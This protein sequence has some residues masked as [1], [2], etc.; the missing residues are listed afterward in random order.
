MPQIRA[1]HNCPAHPSSQVAANQQGIRL[2]Q[3]L[4][5]E[6]DLDTVQAYMGFIQHNAEHAV[7]RMLREFAA[8]H[9]M[10]GEGTVYAEDHM[11]DGSRISLRITIDASSGDAVFDFSGTD[12]EVCGVVWCGVAWCGARAHNP[13][14]LNDTRLQVFGNHNAPPT[15]T[16]SAVIYSLRCLVGTDIPLNQGCL[17][18]V[19]IRIPEV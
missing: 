10:E 12:P 5:K 16:Y 7:R 13:R 17:A 2:V 4:I 1:R 8:K 9:K 18:P 15:V 11:D 6:Y 19:D 14:C 3:G